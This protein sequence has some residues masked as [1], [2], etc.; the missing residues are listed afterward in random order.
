L[1]SERLKSYWLEIRCKRNI[2]KELRKI[3]NENKLYPDSTLVSIPVT[4]KDFL[5]PIVQPFNHAEQTLREA[6]NEFYIAEKFSPSRILPWTLILKHQ[7]K[8]KVFFEDLPQYLP[9]KTNDTTAKFINLLYLETDGCIQICQDEPFGQVSIQPNE[10]DAEL[11]GSFIIKDRGGSEY[12][13]DWKTLS[14]DQRNKV[15]ADRLEGKILCK[16]I[17]GE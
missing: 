15:I 3:L 13:F 2:R 9:D 14:N 7:I 11:K 1:A 5:S 16:T 17:P 6:E 10:I 8:H 4:E 12:N